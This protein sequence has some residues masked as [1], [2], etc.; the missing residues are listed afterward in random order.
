M[1]TINNQKQY[2]SR[3]VSVGK[4]LI[5][6]V[7][8]LLGVVAAW[9][10]FFPQSPVPRAA[11]QM[12]QQAADATTTGKVKSAFTLSQRLSAYDIE[13]ATQD[14]VVTLTGQVPTEIDRELAEKVARDTR[15]VNQVNNQLAVEP[16]VKPSDASLRESQR[17]TD[18]EIQANLRER[19]AASTELSGKAIQIAVSNRNV[20]LSGE[21][22]TP[23]QKS[24]VEQVAR[25]IT[26]VAGVNNQLN[27]TNPAAPQQE[28]PGVTTRDAELSRQIGFALFNERENFTDVAAI[29]VEC[30][31][32]QV[33]LYGSVAT[34]AERALA[35][36]I[37]REIKGVSNVNNQLQLAIG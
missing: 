28:T 3:G 12:L 35:L 17:V 1:D 31:D 23:A 14:G 20:V 30:K 32:G 9:F 4:I 10:Y 18:L 7:P 16:N 5:V 34:R 13:P 25:S 26:N 21:V 36:R 15:G 37:A 11:G 24:G 22:E 29:K 6:I 8:I 19:L 2:A 33:T 27:V